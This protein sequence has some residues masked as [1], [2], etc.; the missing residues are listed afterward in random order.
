MPSSW[1]CLDAGIVVRLFT[2]PT[3]QEIQSLWRRWLSGDRH[4]TAPTLIRYEI[5]NALF[6]TLRR[7]GLD[8][9]A[10][11]RTIRA[12]FALPI[13][14]HRDDDLHREAVGIAFRFALAA[15]YDAHY[16]ALAERLDADFWT[17]D[18]KLANAVGTA[19]PWVHLVGS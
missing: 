16:L 8:A 10:I 14:L 6:R 9:L 11:D 7:D 12:A 19:L 4:L 1:T 15:A 3:N 17:A 2:E 18:K 5:S 13:Q